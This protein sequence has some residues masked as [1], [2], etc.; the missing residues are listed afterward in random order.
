MMPWIVRYTTRIRQFS[1]KHFAVIVLGC[2]VVLTL[3][4]WLNRFVQDD[5]FISFRYAQHLAEGSGLVW[6]L[7]ERIEGYSNFLWVLLIAGIIRLGLDPVIGSFV[8]GLASFAISLFA[9]YRIAFFVFR[10]RWV[11]LFCMVL[12]GTNYSFSAYATGG[13]ETQFLAALLLSTF[14]LVFDTVATKRWTHRRLLLLSFLASFALLTRL[15][16]FLLLAVAGIVLTLEAF[17]SGIPLPRLLGLLPAALLPGVVIIGTWLAWKGAYYGSILP[18]TFY[19][20]FTS[21][22]GLERGISYVVFFLFSY[23]ILPFVFLGTTWFFRKAKTLPLFLGALLACILIWTAYIVKIGGDFMEFRLFIPIIPSIIILCVWIA[24]S[25]MSSFVGK[26]FLVS[27]L[28][29]GSLHHTVTFDHYGF[30]YGIENIPSLERHVRGYEEWGEV[31]RVLGDAFRHDTDVLIAA[32]PAGAIPYYSELPTIDMLGLN[33]PWVAR[34]G[35]ILDDRPGHNR[36][37]TLQY[38]IDRGVNLIVLPWVA[39]DGRRFDPKDS[40]RMFNFASIAEVRKIPKTTRV[41]EI[42]LTKGKTASVVYL[43][44]SPTIDE[45]VARNGWTIYPIVT[46]LQDKAVTNR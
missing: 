26:F 22:N 8:L 24:F 27:L 44:P 41:I 13:L 6:N 1:E 9:S 18:N 12:V 42:P 16:S 37:A 15:D 30:Y 35:K 17:R 34:N 3:L 39:H 32:Q 21:Y 11:A 7:G 31:G 25:S 10:K 28:A 40:I 19:A 5:A 23:W 2:I 46:H 20:K 45:V 29:V 4:A 43:T 14:A 33:D 36:I 38:L